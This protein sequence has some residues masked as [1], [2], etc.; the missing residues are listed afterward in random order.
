MRTEATADDDRE[1]AL[2]KI[3]NVYLIMWDLVYL[4]LSPSIIAMKALSHVYI[5][6]I[7]IPSTDSLISLILYSVNW[8]LY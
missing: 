1:S 3:R 5:L 2:S 8:V 6:S 7:L 4:C